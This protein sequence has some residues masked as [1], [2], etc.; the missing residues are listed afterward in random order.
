MSVRP[1]LLK[2][3]RRTAISQHQ[4]NIGKNSYNRYD[5]LSPR[6]RSFSASKR[7]R[8]EDSEIEQ[9]PKTPKLD[10][11]LIFSQLGGQEA[12]MKE[13]KT[14]FTELDALNSN[15]D[16]PADPRITCM[17]KILSCMFKAHETLTSAVLD[18]VKL[19]T[20]ANAKGKGVKTL[21]PIVLGPAGGTTTR[22]TVPVISEEE[23]TRKKIRSTLKEA[24]KR[25]VIFDLNLG[26]SQM[27]NRDS[28]SRKVTTT[29]GQIVKAG[30]HD[31]DVADAEDVIDDILS[32]SKLEFLGKTTKKFF[33]KRNPA[34]NRNEKMYTVPVRLDFRD[35]E[36]RF[37]AELSLRK[38]CKVNCSTPYPRK[39]RTMLSELVKE[40]KKSN[41]DSFIRTKVNV[42]RLTIEAH[43]K[44]EGGWKDLGLMQ[45]IPL[46]ILDNN[47]FAPTSS[48][49]ASMEEDEDENISLS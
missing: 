46:N 5:V 3:L 28:I 31:Y 2:D 7:P 34:D 36:T 10:S 42:D 29:L 40:G 6:D 39:L 16:L 20:K 35:R 41:P 49:A 18:A 19:D 21:P 45:E 47:P 22:P 43:A 1:V 12:A 38:I 48:Q 32:C 4:Q 44:V 27:M 13:A 15:P 24:E 23:A 33:N 25:T 11:N 14:L 17:S 8:S 37:N 9:V 26:T 30:K